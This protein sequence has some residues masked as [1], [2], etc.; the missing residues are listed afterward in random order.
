[1]LSDDGQPPRLRIRAEEEMMPLRRFRNLNRKF[2]GF[3]IFGFLVESL[4]HSRQ[5]ICM[6]VTMLE[7][8]VMILARIHLLRSATARLRIEEN[9][10]L[11]FVLKFEVTACGA[12]ITVDYYSGQPHRTGPREIAR[13]SAGDRANNGDRRGRFDY[14]FLQRLRTGAAVNP[15]LAN[16]LPGNKDI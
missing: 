3:S 16:I 11:L 15:R 7:F 4:E 6:V 9:S 12:T 13:G 5:K 8:P 14:Y 1:M 10:L 2:F